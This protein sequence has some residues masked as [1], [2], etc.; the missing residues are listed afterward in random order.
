MA[1]SHPR[2]R[3]LGRIEAV[4]IASRKRSVLSM[5]SVRIRHALQISSDTLTQLAY[6]WRQSRAEQA[7]PRCS[8][9]SAATKGCRWTS[10]SRPLSSTVNHA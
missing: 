1:T 6:R 4:H 9:A 2:H 7:V 5:R 3:V 10:T 8:S